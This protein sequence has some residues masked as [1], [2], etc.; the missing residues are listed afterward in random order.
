MVGGSCELGRVFIYANHWEVITNAI[1]NMST[2]CGYCTYIIV[3]LV[4]VGRCRV[5]CVE[6]WGTASRV[7]RRGRRVSD[8]YSVLSVE[9]GFDA[10]L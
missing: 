5:I 3:W 4:C 9:I 1:V 7:E 10:S 2:R 8:T 6:G